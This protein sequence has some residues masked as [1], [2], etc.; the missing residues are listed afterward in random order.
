[1]G[2]VGKAISKITPWN[3]GTEGIIPINHITPW[4]DNTT[5]GKLAN[6][7]LLAAAGYGAGQYFSGAN[8]ANTT[9]A[10][11]MATAPSTAAGT[12]GAITNSSVS[13]TAM[14]SLES[15]VTGGASDAALASSV[16]A[17]AIPNIQSVVTG[18]TPAVVTPTLNPT[19]AGSGTG[20]SLSSLFGSGT[21]N[22]SS[23]GVFSSI[24]SWAKENPMLATMAAAGTIQGVGMYLSAQEQT[25]AQK[26]AIKEQRRQFDALHNY[27]GSF[28]GKGGLLKTPQ[29]GIK[30][31]NSVVDAKEILQKIQYDPT[32]KK[33]FETTASK[34][35]NP[36]E[37]N[38][39]LSAYKKYMGV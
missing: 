30:Q 31:V 37:A 26:E 4:N 6:A 14:P 22:A 36:D 7:V 38:A 10:S 5:E 20:S 29:A 28:G 34:L 17:N 15:I 3:D 13:A 32:Y 27:G 1:M 12:G 21:T 9:T 33:G 25:K 24:G 39:I 18:A 8:A 11:Q 35:I 19:V 23:S 2:S 16:S